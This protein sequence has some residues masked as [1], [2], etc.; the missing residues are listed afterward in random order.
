MHFIRK[1]N[2]LLVLGGRRIGYKKDDP[3]KRNK[4]IP[5]NFILNMVN[6]EW[7]ILKL[8]DHDITGLYN[9]ASCQIE[10][11]VYVF[12]GSM[13]PFAQSKQ[14][15]KISHAEIKRSEAQQRSASRG[16]NQESAR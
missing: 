9:F 4:D 14:L 8:R 5:Q 13:I 10:D 15:F 2:V 16:H 12:G 3:M 7:S 6:L 11:D 1:A